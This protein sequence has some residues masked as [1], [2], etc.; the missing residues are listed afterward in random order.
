MIKIFTDSMMAIWAV[1]I[2]VAV[3]LFIY[4]S[5]RGVTID[6]I[7]QKRVESEVVILQG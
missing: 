6:D 3:I 2:I 5:V 1:L 7:R 4:F